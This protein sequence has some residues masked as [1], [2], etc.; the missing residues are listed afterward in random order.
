MYVRDRRIII[1]L[2]RERERERER[3]HA[4]SLPDKARLQSR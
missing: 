1:L 2:G 4:L 3:E